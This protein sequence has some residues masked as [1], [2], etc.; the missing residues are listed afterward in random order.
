MAALEV[1]ARDLGLTDLQLSTGNR[2]PEAVA[3]YEATGWERLHV[4]REGR[5]LPDWH[6]RFDK[7]VGADE[8]ATG[9]R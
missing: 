6:F 9:G 1:V 4:D 8:E 2:Q 7:D 5:P 3:L